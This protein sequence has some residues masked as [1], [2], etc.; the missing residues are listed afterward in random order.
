MIYIVGNDKR[1]NYVYQYM[2]AKGKDALYSP[3]SELVCTDRDIILVTPPKAEADKLEEIISSNK[4]RAVYTGVS[5]AGLSELCDKNGIQII[6]YLKS[7]SVV[8]ENAVLT[9]NG[10]IKLTKEEHD[11]DNLSGKNCLVLGY[12][13]C[14]KALAEALLMEKAEVT[15]SVRREELEGE[16][17]S[18]GYEYLPL[19][20]LCEGIG[21]GDFSYIYNTIPAP[22][23]GKD[24]IDCMKYMLNIYDLASKPGGTDFSYCIKKGI[25]AKL[26]L[27]IPGMYYPKEAGI[28]IA[29]YI[30]E[31]L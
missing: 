3:Q 31:T 20:S 11:I 24:V 27:G 28:I 26:I 9:A 30:L 13:N 18:K 22:V 1:M 10:I 2:L 16:I 15:V 25:N 21:C 5:D 29:S 17:K 19:N 14:G 23:I 12:G 4:V 7:P 8:Y 6:Y